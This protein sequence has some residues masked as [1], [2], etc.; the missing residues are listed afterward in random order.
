MPLAPIP[1]CRTKAG[2]TPLHLAAMKGDTKAIAALVNAG[3]DLNVQDTDGR[4]PM[5]WAAKRGHAKAVAALTNAGADPNILDSELL[6]PRDL[7]E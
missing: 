2:L 4:T 7:L 3:A 6:K 1:T 5:H